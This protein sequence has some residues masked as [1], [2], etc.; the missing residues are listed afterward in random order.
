L[1]VNV[2]FCCADAV[3]TVSANPAATADASFQIFMRTS[4]GVDRFS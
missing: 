4:P 2:S 1:S 3:D